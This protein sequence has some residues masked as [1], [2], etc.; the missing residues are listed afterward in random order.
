MASLPAVRA[1]FS[2]LGLST[3]HGLLRLVMPY[4][5]RVSAHSGV[6]VLVVAALA[7]ALGYRI[8][9]RTLRFAVEVALVAA[10]LFGA[11]ELGW[12]RF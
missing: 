5:H 10:A 7:I 9:K 11:T 12:I 8:L 2:I 1:A 4:L 6:P 3:F